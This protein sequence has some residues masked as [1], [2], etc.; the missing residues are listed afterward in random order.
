MVASGGF[1]PPSIGPEPTILGRYTTRL[2]LRII[3]KSNNIKLKLADAVSSVMLLV[4]LEEV[5]QSLKQIPLLFLDL[6]M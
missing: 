6:E 4:S 1:E 5:L 3:D 2:Y